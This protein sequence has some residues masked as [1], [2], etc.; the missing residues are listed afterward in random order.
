M[1]PNVSVIIPTYNSSTTLVSALDSVFAQN[2]KDY[3][4]IVVD[5]GSQ[6]NTSAILADYSDRIRLYECSERGAGPARNY[7]V[8][9]ALGKFIS[10]L[11]ADD[12]W[13][14]S[15]LSRQLEFHEKQTDQRIISGSYASFLGTNSRIIGTSPRTRN[16]TV[17]TIGIVTNG[18]MPAPLSTW[19]MSREIFDEV[20]GFDSE[21]TFSQ[22]LEFLMRAVRSGIE[23]KILR[24]ELCNYSLSYSSGTGGHYIEQYLAAK[25]LIESSHREQ[26]TSLQ[27]FIDKNSR[28][29]S[30]Y[31]LKSRAGKSFRLAIIDY[32]EG[33]VLTTFRRLMLSFLLDPI[34]FIKKILT[35][36]N[37]H[38]N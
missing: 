13:L 32:G 20:G 18:T 14:E 34:R 30:R 2:Y 37:S 22:D 23:M 38:G 10:F 29:F 1:H 17:A 24:E 31:Y 6:D 4:V 21:Y 12:S 28:F 8:S 27:E 16:D 5:N 33:K 3:E 19:L 7:G 11:D 25:Y 35:Q 9:K 36:A 26:D 15:K